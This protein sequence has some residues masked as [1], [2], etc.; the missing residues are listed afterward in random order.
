[1]Q[2]TLISDLYEF[3]NFVPRDVLDTLFEYLNEHQRLEFARHIE[4]VLQLDLSKWSISDKSDPIIILE[5]ATQYFSD[6]FQRD[7]IKYIDSI[8][9]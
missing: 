7:F 4:R 8:F 1:M 3:E 9:D 5:E 2:A 6:R